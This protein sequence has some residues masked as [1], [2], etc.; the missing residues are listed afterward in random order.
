MYKKH[1]TCAMQA[2]P[3][4]KLTKKPF[5]SLCG[6]SCATDSILESL[7][8]GCDITGNLSIHK[9]T[10]SVRHHSSC[11]KS[12]LKASID[13]DTWCPTDI[14]TYLHESACCL[15][16]LYFPRAFTDRESEAL[17]WLSVDSM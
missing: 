15:C 17:L 4:V 7:I 12:L 1:A 14:D 11:P 16:L 8:K 6:I 13:T 9:T 3:H 5:F 10:Q 2:W